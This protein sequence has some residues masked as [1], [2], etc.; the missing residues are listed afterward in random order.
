MFQFIDTYRTRVR[1][2]IYNPT[3]LFWHCTIICNLVFGM[4]PSKA[5]F[6]KSERLGTYL[7]CT[8]N[9]VFTIKANSTYLPR[10]CLEQGSWIFWTSGM[11]ETL[12]EQHL[13]IV[14][15]QLWFAIFESWRK[16]T[17]VIG[18][19]ALPQSIMLLKNLHKLFTW[20]LLL[21]TS[22]LNYIINERI[23]DASWYKC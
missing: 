8:A 16:Q 19:N 11:R 5:H 13:R 17:K 10:Q 14:L 4:R 3:D 1:C 20:T 7:Y 6:R 23:K 22:E 21:V 2:K 12:S 15:P 18:N 9:F